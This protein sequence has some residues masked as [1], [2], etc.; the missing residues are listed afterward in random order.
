M[1]LSSIPNEERLRRVVLDSLSSAYNTLMEG[2]ADK[3]T[4][5]RAIPFVRLASCALQELECCVRG[6]PKPKIGD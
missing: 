1:S 4:V 5:Y 2:T 6:V 3:T